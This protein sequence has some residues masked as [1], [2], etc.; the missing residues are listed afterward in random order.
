MLGTADPKVLGLA[1]LSSLLPDC[2]NSGSYVGRLLR[3]L[4]SYL[5]ERFPHRTITHSFVATLVIGLV[6]LPLVWVGG[7]GGWVSGYFWGWFADAFTKSGVTAFWPHRARLV[8][9]GNPKL[10]LTTGSP[11]EWWVLGL[12]L[13][14][15]LLS[16]NIQS[17]GGLLRTFNLWMGIPNGAAELVNQDQD[18]YLLTAQIDGIHTLTQQR[19]RG[20]FQVVRSLTTTDLLVEQ[21][22]KLYRVGASTG[23]QIRISRIFIRRE[24]PIRSQVETLNWEDSPFQLPPDPGQPLH[25]YYSGVMEL[26]AN[27][28]R[29]LPNLEVFIPITL[30]KLDANRVLV[31]VDSARAQDL[32]P[33]EGYFGSGQL[34][35]RRIYPQ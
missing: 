21:E 17:Q 3:P 4:S 31:E 27:D 28:L 20:K 23:A 30:K 22:G 14:A 35:I 7:W 25:V 12:S 8:I 16:L 1:A 18:R 24:R 6:G 33:L 29:I 19:V 32:R 11:A 15:L 5:E 13:V 26:E 34:I 2:D 9:P 10:R